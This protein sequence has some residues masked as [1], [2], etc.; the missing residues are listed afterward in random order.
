MYGSKNMI[1]LTFGT[2]L[3]AGLILDGKLYEGTNGNAGEIGHIR[4]AD[5]GPEGYGKIGSFEGFCSGGGIAR[6]GYLMFKEEISNGISINYFDEKK[7]CGGLS[8][9]ILAD[10]AYKGDEFAIRVYNECGKRL[11]MGLSILIDILNPEC[12][13]IGSVFARSGDLL[14]PAMQKIIS[15]E[16]LNASANVCRIV[17]AALG[18][19]IGDYAALITAIL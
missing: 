11:G 17:P 16:A 3:G 8:A 4:L 12:I 15:K 9:K 5:N 7:P 19:Q 6:L 10:A 13:V 18:E 2:G 1:F 14:I